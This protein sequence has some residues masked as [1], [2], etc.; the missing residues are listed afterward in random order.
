[1]PVHHQAGSCPRI[2]EP[3]TVLPSDLTAIVFS[4]LFGSF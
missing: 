1:M 4:N 2:E 3:F